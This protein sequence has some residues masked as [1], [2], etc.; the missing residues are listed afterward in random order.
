VEGRPLREQIDDTPTEAQL[1]ARARQ[2]DLA[3]YEDL[4]RRHQEVAF[5]TAVLLAGGAMEAD[6]AVQDAFLKAHAALGR[7]RSDAP[8]RPWLLAIVANEARNRRRASGRRQALALRIA[9]DRPVGEAAP[10]PEAAVLDHEQRTELLAALERL[11][12]EDR[13]VVACRYLLQLSEAETAEVLRCPKGTVKSRL[14]RALARLRTDLE[15]REPA[16]TGGS[17]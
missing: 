8:F 1:I 11:R 13:E 14:S 4:V 3:A 2:G 15:S 5:R 10:S 16:T 9:E 6:D 7:F 12:P 17:R